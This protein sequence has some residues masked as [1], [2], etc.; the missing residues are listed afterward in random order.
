MQHRTKSTDRERYYLLTHH[1]FKIR[2]NI[3]FGSISLFLSGSRFVFAARKLSVKDPAGFTTEL[4]QI[5][6]VERFSLLTYDAEDLV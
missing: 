1:M 3:M 2:S 5:E 6:G 4:G